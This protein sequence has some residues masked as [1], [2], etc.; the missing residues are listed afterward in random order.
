MMIP[1]SWLSRE[2]T[3]ALGWSL[4]HFCWQGTAVALAYAFANRITSHA[5]S[6]VRYFVA[7]A[8]FML[9]PA[10]V[11]STFVLECDP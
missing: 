11:L 10:V 2:E 6:R 7:L 3:V 5:S 1:I 9:M 8:A 4:L